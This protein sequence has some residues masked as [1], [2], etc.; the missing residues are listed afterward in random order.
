MY[1]AQPSPLIVML[2]RTTADYTAAKAG[3]IAFHASLKAEL[4]RSTHPGAENIKTVLVTP[5]QLG[6]SL[7]GGLKTPSTFLAPVVEPVELAKEIVK[8]VD[9][10][11]SGEVSL[12]LYTRLAPLLPALPSGIWTVGRALSGMDGAMLDF[13]KQKKS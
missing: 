8:A 10:G 3:L 5:G 2:T 13:S 7:F 1:V 12:P 11:W 9:S 4:D 6:T